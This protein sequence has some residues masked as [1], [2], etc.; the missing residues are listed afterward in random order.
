L[1]SNVSVLVRIFTMPK[2]DDLQELRDSSAQIQFLLSE[3]QHLSQGLPP[4]STSDQTKFKKLA[5]QGATIGVVQSDT[6]KFINER[7]VLF[8]NIK[9]L[10]EQNAELLKVTRVVGKQLEDHEARLQNEAETQKSRELEDM[11]QTME[12]M[13]DEIHN[14]EKRAETFV[15]ER[16]M[17]RRMLQHRNQLPAEMHSQD[18]MAAN[19]LGEST[20]AIE[21][22][23]S[24][25]K[26]DYQQLL[27]ELQ[28]SFDQYKSEAATDHSTLREQAA[29]LQNEKNEL[30]IQ[31]TRVNGQLELANCKRLMM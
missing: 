20:R 13:R 28:Q 6:D 16:D 27:R 31:I 5:L 21:A 3:V 30:Q 14:L 19:Q 17:F 4:L 8:R 9:E 23:S 1:S 18:E 15:K 7:L 2:A 22:A 29:R 24:G 12:N 25:E 10:Q 11:Q 26:E